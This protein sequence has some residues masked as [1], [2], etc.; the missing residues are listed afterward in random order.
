MK[1]RVT[2]V[3]LSWFAAFMIIMALFVAFGAQLEDLP[4]P[5]RALSISGVLVFRMTQAVIPLKNRLLRS[6]S[7]N[8]AKR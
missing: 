3:L 2:F 4:L 7:R 1:A 8:T 5:L 6:A